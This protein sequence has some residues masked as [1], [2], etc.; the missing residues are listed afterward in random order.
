MKAIRIFALLIVLFFTRSIV[1]AYEL[2]THALLTYNAVARSI[3]LRDPS[4]S[5]DL[6]VDVSSA[7]VIGARYFDGT[8]VAPRERTARKFEAD[9]MP[10]LVHEQSVIGW[11]MRGAIREDDV[12]LTGCLAIKYEARNF[13]EECN[14]RDD[15]YG[16]I[17]RPLHHFYDPIADRGLNRFPFSVFRQPGAGLGSGPNGL[18]RSGRRR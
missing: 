15:P 11:L 9:R 2:R 13:L 10:D 14:P 12:A 1:L 3:L 6:G 5:K 16:D 8:A 4:L 17:E 18:D 7:A